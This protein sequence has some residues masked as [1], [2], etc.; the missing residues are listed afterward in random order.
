[1]TPVDHARALAA[2]AGPGEQVEVYLRASRTVDVEVRDGRVEAFCAATDTGVSVRVVADHREGLA[3]AAHPDD[4]PGAL[5]TARTNAATS[6]PDPALGLY[7]AGACPGPAAEL[8]LWCDDV[9]G[10][11]VEDKVALALALEQATLGADPRIRGTEV[12]AYRDAA[13]EIV[14]CTSTGVEVLDRRT[15][16]TVTTVA[17][18]DDDDGTRTG[19]GL[20]AGR[21]VADL[22]VDAAATDAA[23]RALRL[24]GAAP[25]R[26]RRT[27]VVFDPLVTRSL[28]ALVGAALGGDAV[29]RGR[30]IFVDRLGEQVAAGTVTLVE[31]P[32]LAE[33]WGAA[34]HDGE[35]VPTRRCP[36]IEGGRL[37]TFLHNVT[38]ARR[39]GTRTTGS[40][41]RSLRAPPG[42]AARAL[43]LTGG[44]RGFEEIVAT[45]GDAFYVQSVTGLHAGANVVSGDLSL[46]AVGCLV[47]GG[48]LAQPVREVTIASTLPRLLRS[49]REV[50]AD[51]RWMP[52]SAAG[53]TLVVDDMTLSGR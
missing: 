41:V 23:T 29:L 27:A 4:L 18:A 8:D 2:A 5:A 40:A 35:G 22:D 38:S 50:G 15:S 7:E 26:S 1:M 34:A 52:G 9:P 51:L 39:A 25:V 33:A 24:L 46:G 48:A 3:W 28:L 49:V 53:C 16:C 44:R 47:Q 37:V 45:V 32:T 31:D 6:E 42:V 17:M 13:T 20:S 21:R 12:V 11:P 19:W 10:T 36:L 43:H 14:L 30:S